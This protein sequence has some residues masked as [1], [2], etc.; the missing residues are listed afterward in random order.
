[1]INRSLGEGEER[2]I[3][4]VDGWVAGRLGKGGGG[5]GRRVMH[6]GIEFQSC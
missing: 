5:E 6:F 4:G 3:L 2:A 1:M